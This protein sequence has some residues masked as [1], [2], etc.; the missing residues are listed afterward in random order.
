MRY[1]RL[2]LFAALVAALAGCGARSTPSH[3][4]RP[5][6][7][8][9]EVRARFAGIPQGGTV[10]GP[11]SAPVT[12]VEFGDLQCPFCRRFDREVMPEL[13]RRYVRTGQV[14]IDFRPVPLLGPDS[15]RA[16]RAALAAAEQNRL[17]QFVDLFYW[18]QGR[19]NTGYVTDDFLRALAGGVTGLDAGR[20]LRTRSAAPVD[21]Q[22]RANLALARQIGIPGT[23]TFLVGPTGGR[24][25]RFN[26]TPGDPRPFRRIFARLLRRAA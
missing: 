22:V 15:L 26:V 18:N 7:A 3:R 25:T 5:I 17:W 6:G 24:M 9:P 1:V 19:E 2:A 14:R 16:A 13:L 20:L 23:P 10:L 8:V 21:T 11:P 12:L 4:A